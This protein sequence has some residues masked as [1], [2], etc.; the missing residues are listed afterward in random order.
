[1]TRFE[2][3]TS[4]LIDKHLT[5]CAIAFTGKHAAAGRCYNIR[6]C[7]VNFVCAK[8]KLGVKMVEFSDGVSHLDSR[9]HKTCFIR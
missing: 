3:T 4:C 2:L 6:W 8:K 5:S 1:M 7:S 9:R